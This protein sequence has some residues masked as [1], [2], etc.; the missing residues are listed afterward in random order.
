MAEKIADMRE[1]SR[2]RARTASLPASQQPQRKTKDRFA[3]RRNRVVG[4]SC[5]GRKPMSHFTT[6]ATKINN[7]VCLL[8]A[9]DK[10]KLRHTHAEQGVEVRGWRGQKSTAEVS[11]N[12]G[13][14]D[15]G[16]VKT[17]TAPGLQAD[18]WGVE[19]T[20]GKTEQEVVDEINREYAYQTVVVVCEA[21]GYKIESRTSPRTVR[22]SSLCRSGA[23]GFAKG[24]QGVQTMAQRKELEITISPSG[25]VSVQVKCIPGQSCVEET[26]FL[27]D[28]L[29]TKSK[30]VSS[31]SDYYQQGNTGSTGIYNRG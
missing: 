23:S 22:S 18:W 6:V 17:K 11:I 12:M 26:K 20:V 13:R 8:K 1:W 14:Y 28:A 16:V 9:L 31:P 5:N 25:E 30:T 21:Q 19:T 24:Q 29:E 15:I 7:I 3:C 27:E 4:L 10:L 2:T